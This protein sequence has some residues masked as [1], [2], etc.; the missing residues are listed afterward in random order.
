MP[1]FCALKAACH[2][3]PNYTFAPNC[4][5]YRGVVVKKEPP[6][7]RAVLNE[8]AFR[9]LIRGKE[10]KLEGIGAD[11]KTVVRLIL[12]DLGFDAML[13]AIAVA[14]AEGGEDVSMF[15][16]TPTEPEKLIYPNPP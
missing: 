11:G 4:E 8:N 9:W 10:V 15:S 3:G 13:R 5:N 2:C 12:T 6:E 16:D 14:V 7:I 1:N